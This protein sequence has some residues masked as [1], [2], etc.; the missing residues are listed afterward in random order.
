MLSSI[1]LPKRALN[2][3]KFSLI[4]AVVF[5]IFYYIGDKITLSS[6]KIE[7]KFGITSEKEMLDYLYFSLV[8][9][10]TIGMDIDGFG[11]REFIDPNFKT[12]KLTRMINMLQLISVI[13]CT[14]LAI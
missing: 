10:S 2:W 6:K 1:I 13:Y 7:K 14:A 9:Q 12:N 8:T 11:Y 3:F 5:A 4:S